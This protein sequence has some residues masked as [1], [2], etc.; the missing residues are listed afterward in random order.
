ML[1]FWNSLFCA[2]FGRQH[3]SRWNLSKLCSII[4]RLVVQTTHSR[5]PSYNVKPPEGSRSALITSPATSV[6]CLWFNQV[7]FQARAR[8]QTLENVTRSFPVTSTDTNAKKCS[9]WKLWIWTLIWTW[10]FRVFWWCFSLR[11]LTFQLSSF[12]KSWNGNFNSLI[13]GHNS[14]SR[15]DSLFPVIWKM[16]RWPLNFAERSWNAQQKSW[17][18]VFDRKN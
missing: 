10:F 8:R 17:N 1:Y 4:H 13:F 5:P 12:Q 18:T 9:G 6:S 3:R 14:T 15:D 11:F 16:S 7:P 2:A